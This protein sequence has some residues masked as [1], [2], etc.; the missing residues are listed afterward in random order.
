MNHD[1]ASGMG[2]LKIPVLYVDKKTTLRQGG[3]SMYLDT[4]IQSQ[5]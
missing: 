3:N 4:S 5:C 1:V 2:I